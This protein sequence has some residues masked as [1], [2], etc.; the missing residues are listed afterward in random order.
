MSRN[1]AR[2]FM[3]GGLGVVV[4]FGVVVGVGLAA[5]VAGPDAVLVATGVLEASGDEL[6]S[7]PVADGE[8]ATVRARSRGAAA[9]RRISR[10]YVVS[11][12]TLTRASERP[13]G[14]QDVPPLGID[15]IH[16]EA[17]VAA[18]TCQ[19]C[20][21]Y[22]SVS[23]EPSSFPTRSLACHP[24]AGVFCWRRTCGVQA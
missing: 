17:I 20:S 18:C 24:A 9:A 4:G 2:A 19:D 8:Q 11:K 12:T 21:S 15:S 13:S 22:V 10:P 3:A 16:S 6:A 23:A 1:A 7:E 14:S 5:R